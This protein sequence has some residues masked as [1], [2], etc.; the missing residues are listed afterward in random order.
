MS[1]I[2]DYSLNCYNLS[3]EAY[4]DQNP[5]GYVK[6]GCNLMLKVLGKKKNDVAN[7]FVKDPLEQENA[8]ILI[9]TL[10]L[11]PRSPAVEGT[12]PRD[13]KAMLFLEAKS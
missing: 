13:A 9:K 1:V 10:F 7:L 3:C 8:F 2:Y 5:S 12:L 6:Q 4:G 11:T